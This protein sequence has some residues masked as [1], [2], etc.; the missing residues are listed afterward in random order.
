MKKILLVIFIFV[1]AIQYSHAQLISIAA[2]RAMSTGSVVTVR[3]IVL[4][5][6][7]LAGGN[8]RYI[9]DGTGGLV[10]YGANMSTLNRGD[11][12]QATGTVAPYN[13]LFELSPVSSF[14]VLNNGNPS[15]IPNVQ[16]IPTGFAEA[17]EANLVRFNNVSF[18]GSGTFAGN[19]NYPITDGTNNAT[20]RIANGSALIGTA[21]PG[22]NVNIV[23]IMSQ[24]TTTYQLLPRDLNDFPTT[25]TPPVFTSGL[26]Q[27]NIAQSSFTVSF[28]TQINGNTII[29]YGL[30]PS[31][32][33]TATDATMATNHSINLTGLAAAT[34]Y[35]VKGVTVSATND[36]SFTTI[37]P[38]A[39]ASNSSGN[40][41][42]Y[43]TRSVDNSVATVQNAIQLN[44][45]TDDTLIAYIGRAHSTLDIA[46]YNMDNNLNV[47][48][49]LNNAYNNGV[50]VRV[51]A[52]ASI[53]A[54]AWSTLSIGSASNKKLAPSTASYGIMHDKFMIIDAN[55]ANPNVPILWTGSTNWTDNQLTV[56]RNNVVIFQ[57]QTIARAY[58]LEFNEM[59]SGNLFGPFKTDN[60]PHEFNIGGKSVQVYFSPSDN[61]EQHIKDAALSGN[62][63]EE[64][65]LYVLTRTQLAYGISDAITNNGA[66]AYGIVSDTSS[67]TNAWNILSAVMP[68]TLFKYTGSNLLH[69]KYLIVDANL[70]SSDP[71]VVTGS[72]NW[73]GSAQQKND[74]NTVVIH[75][76][77]IAN[78]YYQEFVSR[79]HD[80]GGTI[81]PTYLGVADNELKISASLYP[82]P[83]DGQFNVMYETETVGQTIFSIT[84][85]TGKIIST[86][87][88]NAKTGMNKISFD[89]QNFNSGLY[90]IHISNGTESTTD[91]FMLSK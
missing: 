77:N 47:V 29:Q 32:G 54:S 6:G 44:N 33:Q 63:D 72:H 75:D 78:Q 3:G 23:G 49:A 70:P 61:T 31:L 50:A 48:N 66:S 64:F 13:N 62:Q 10:L 17:F 19:T 52:D 40:I 15:P 58:E 86:Q 30:T 82:N 16:T 21:I 88:L 26:K 59:F 81:L 35:Y 73:S 1:S 34:I 20:V 14:T 22:G 7:E 2:A 27:T 65:C 28:T 46:I 51:V 12:V 90:F 67:G 83:N 91:K 45:V 53:N 60:T 69:H 56:D 37:Q 55:D 36:T 84:D 80:E 11:S 9:Y 42:V 24:F 74:E 39:T 71:M 41:K 68:N 8:T 85:V 4:N 38:M 79:Y 76:A 25:G 57:D 5:G 87:V 89:M 43:F 18:T